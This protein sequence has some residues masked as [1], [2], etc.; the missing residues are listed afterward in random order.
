MHNA[1]HV[2]F[3]SIAFASL[4][5]ISLYLDRTHVMLQYKANAE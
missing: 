2:S 3:L 4:I 5:M 1:I